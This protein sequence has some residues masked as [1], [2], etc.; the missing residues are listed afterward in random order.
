M[1]EVTKKT[2][3]KNEI[4]NF[5]NTDDKGLIRAL[6][7]IFYLQTNEEQETQSTHI[8]NGFGFNKPDSRRLTS[9]AQQYINDNWLSQRQLNYIRKRLVKYAGQLAEIANINSKIKTLEN[10]K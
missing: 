2:W 5:I 9:M 1:K 3:T 6:L 7:L 10:K 4:I 8:Y